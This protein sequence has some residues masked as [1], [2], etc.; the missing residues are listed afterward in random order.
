MLFYNNKRTSDASYKN[1]DTYMKKTQENKN[2]SGDKSLVTATP[3]PVNEEESAVNNI[4]IDDGEA[5]M[6]NL[7]NSASGL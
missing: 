4:V 2:V 7:E 5:D 3:T 6:M 1:P